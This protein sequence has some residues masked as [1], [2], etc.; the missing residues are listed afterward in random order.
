VIRDTSLKTSRG[1]MES[2][3]ASIEK[4]FKRDD[5]S[6]SGFKHTRQRKAK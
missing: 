3:Q 5:F 6:L 4:R 2:R 1:F